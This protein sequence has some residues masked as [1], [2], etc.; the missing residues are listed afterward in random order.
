M[1]NSQLNKM[2]NDLSDIQLQIVYLNMLIIKILSKNN[3]GVLDM[4][5]KLID[6]IK[7]VKERVEKIKEEIQE[8]LN[9]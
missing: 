3:Y 1:T 5:K 7:I 6:E 2:I 8:Y 9:I 4:D